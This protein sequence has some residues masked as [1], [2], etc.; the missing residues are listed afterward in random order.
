MSTKKTIVKHAKQEFN[1]SARQN[2]LFKVLKKTKSFKTNAELRHL[3]G[4]TNPQN[5]L[6]EL[7]AMGMN[8]SKKWKEVYNE[9]GDLVR[10][11]LYRLEAA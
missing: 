6:S 10:V 5:R 4:I 9:Q 11:K 2:Q 7:I 1:L 3:T 8:I